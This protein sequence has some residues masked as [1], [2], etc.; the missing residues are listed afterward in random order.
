M[1][2]SVDGFD[3]LGQSIKF[4]NGKRPHSSHGGR[5]PDQAYFDNLPK[6]AA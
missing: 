6:A 1:A 4:H 2:R 3:S 5:T